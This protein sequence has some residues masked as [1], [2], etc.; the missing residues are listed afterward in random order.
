[1]VREYAHDSQFGHIRLLNVVSSFDDLPVGGV[2][3]C[4][5]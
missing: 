2:V 1:M 4:V 5:K 3:I